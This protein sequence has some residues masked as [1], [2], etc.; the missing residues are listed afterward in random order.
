[1][2]VEGMG[3]SLAV[4]GAIDATALETYLEQV[5]LPELQPRQIVVMDN[6][7]A[8]KGDRVRELVE[9]RLR[10]AVPGALLSDQAR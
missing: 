4:S 9:E 10:V 8:Q 1:M 5:L 7:S 2:S 3:A 6:L